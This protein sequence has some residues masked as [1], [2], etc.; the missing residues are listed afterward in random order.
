MNFS[1][2]NAQSHMTMKPVSATLHKPLPLKAKLSQTSSRVWPR[3]GKYDAVFLFV[4]V[5][6]G[7]LGVAAVVVSSSACWIGEEAASIEN[8][9]A[10][11]RRFRSHGPGWSRWTPP[12]GAAA[13]II[14]GSN[15]YYV[16]VV[17]ENRRQRIG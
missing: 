9:R 17:F 15:G 10:V 14:W 7:G 6:V 13:A 1:P 2:G 8:G 3:L 16:A 12:E 11:R 4:P 5:L